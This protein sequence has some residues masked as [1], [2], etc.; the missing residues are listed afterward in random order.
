MSR[1]L[2]YI[3]LVPPTALPVLVLGP[4]LPLRASEYFFQGTYTTHAA[5]A[6]ASAAQCG[7]NFNAIY[8]YNGILSRITKTSSKPCAPHTHVQL[9][10]LLALSISISSR[11]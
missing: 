8:C 3:V 5:S 11:V 4:S 1:R 7:N 10:S 2:V 6:V 9:R